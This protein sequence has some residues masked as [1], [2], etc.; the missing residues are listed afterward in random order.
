MGRRKHAQGGQ[1][2]MKIAHHMRVE[3]SGLAYTALEWVEEEERQGHVA[4][5]REPSTNNVLYGFTDKPDIHIIH[6]QLHPSYYHDDIPKLMIMHGEPLG[7]VG[8]SISMRAIVDLAPLCE[9]FLCMRQEEWAVWNAIRRTYVVPK[10]IDLGRFRPMDPPP[11]P[12]SGKP[13][14]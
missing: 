6:S 5:V 7:S 1:S 3:N 11:A 2:R 12:L 8:N 4:S 13:A 10:G 9:A 14:G